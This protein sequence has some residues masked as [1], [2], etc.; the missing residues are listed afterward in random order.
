MQ[1]SS[2]DSAR[3]N[4]V[5]PLRNLGLIAE[6]GTLTE[7][8]N[9]WRGDLTYPDACDAIIKRFYP[10]ELASLV[11]GNGAPD[12]GQLATWFEHKGFGRSNASQMARTYALIASRTIPEAPQSTPKPGPPNGRALPKKDK[13]RRADPAIAVTVEESK[14]I[15][16]REID[17]VGRSQPN[18][19]LDVQI[20]IPAD[21]TAEQIDKIFASMAKHLYGR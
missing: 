9:L 21:A 3:D 18:L 14:P 2:A 13:P 8:G 17:T 19:H 15:L 7:A 11:D 4:I 20:H 1:M 12:V 16:N 10:E 6:D 5:T